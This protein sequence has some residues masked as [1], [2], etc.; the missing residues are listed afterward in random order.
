MLDLFKNDLEYKQFL[1]YN[2]KEK[3]IKTTNMPLKELMSAV[4][5][6]LDL[7]DLRGEIVRYALNSEIFYAFPVAYL[8]SLLRKV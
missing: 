6:T 7:E 3:M 1:G 5:E 4:L 8:I 2:L